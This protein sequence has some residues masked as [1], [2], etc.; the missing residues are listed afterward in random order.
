MLRRRFDGRHAD[1]PRFKIGVTTVRTAKAEE[2]HTARGEVSAIG[3]S[4]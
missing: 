2:S 4:I 3:I 1:A